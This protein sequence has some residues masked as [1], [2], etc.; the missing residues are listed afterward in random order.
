MG[1]VMGC[2]VGGTSSRCVLFDDAGTLL[3]RGHAAGGNINSSV[4]DP[5]DNLAAALSE[6]LGGNPPAGVTAGMVGMAGSASDPDRATRIGADAW[7]RAGLTGA[8]RVGTDLEI[9]YTAGATGPDG[10]LLLAGTGAIGAAFHDWTMTRRC[11]GLGWLV[12]DEGSAVW[13]GLAAIRAVAAA[14]D[15]RAGPT[16]LTDLLAG[17]LRTALPAGHRST[18]DPR[19]D[20]VTYAHGTTPARFGALAPL[21]ADAAAAGDPVADRIVTAGCDALL[22]TAGVVAEGTRPGCL[23]LAGSLLTT[24]GTI[25]DRVRAGLSE[26]WPGLE[27]VPA[28]DPVAGAVLTALRDAGVG[29]TPESAARVRAELADGAGAG[30]RHK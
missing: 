26:R 7:G 2:D 15:G 25:A 5:A 29:V 19:Q 18:G 1:A 11:D 21:V 8:P 16:A 14:L 12:G 3:G 9:G 13:L 24:P 4:G 17:H 6:A 30:H 22:R 10:V 20:L 23:V 27:P 28:P